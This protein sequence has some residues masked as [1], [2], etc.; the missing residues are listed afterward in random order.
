MTPRPTFLELQ[1]DWY[2][3]AAGDRCWL[4]VSERSVQLAA[5]D[6][7]DDVNS[8]RLEVHVSAPPSVHFELELPTHSDLP[9]PPTSSSSSHFVEVK[10]RE[11]DWI[12]VHAHVGDPSAAR[13][14]VRTVFQAPAGAVAVGGKRQ[15][16][17]VDVSRDERLVAVG[18]VD[19]HCALFNALARTE[20]FNL[21]GHVADVTSVR[22]FP[23]AT[24]LLSASMDFTLRIWN[25]ADGLC[26]AVLKGH[27][28]GIEDTAILGRG[29]NVLCTLTAMER[30]VVW[31]GTNRSWSS[32]GALACSRDGMIHLWSCGTQDVIAKWGNDAQSA[33]HCL[34]VLDAASV[35]TKSKNDDNDDRP[36]AHSQEAETDGK[37]LFAGL[38]NGE[39]L[40]VDI[41]MRQ[42]VRLLALKRTV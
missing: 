14:T 21:R 28:G 4:D 42:L 34:S 22:F 41:R 33:V 2:E 15:L 29:R 6:A 5:S 12:E 20:A 8:G 25:A 24:V 13:R 26:A 31:F 9:P 39:T 10:R 35:A 3:L 32:V 11:R 16:L 19:G 37:V 40:G 30:L 38:E 17:A 7:D 27:R 36:A 23:S 18:G 1:P